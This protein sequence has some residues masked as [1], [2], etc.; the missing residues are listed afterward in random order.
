MQTCVYG[1]S[2]VQSE[3]CRRAHSSSLVGS[4]QIMSKIGVRNSVVYVF[5][6]EREVDR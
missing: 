2:M 1:G 5:T 3:Q 4:H 6:D